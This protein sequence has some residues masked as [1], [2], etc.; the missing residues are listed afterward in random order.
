MKDDG[1]EEGEEAGGGAEPGL[2][3]LPASS[4]E[5][6]FGCKQ[7]MWEVIPGSPRRE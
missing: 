2:S 4:P 5:T 7:F 3:G 6:G 1:E